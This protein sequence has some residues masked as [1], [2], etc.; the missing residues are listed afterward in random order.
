V[1]PKLESILDREAKVTHDA[2][3]AQI[4]ARLGSGEGT[5]ARGPD[6]KVWDKGK[7]LQDVSHFFLVLRLSLIL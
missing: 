5:S 3:S 4:E 2:F 1:S 7:G 6:M